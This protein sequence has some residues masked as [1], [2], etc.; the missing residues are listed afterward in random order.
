MAKNSWV[1]LL[2]WFSIQVRMGSTVAW[3]LWSS[4]LDGQEWVRY[5]AVDWA[6]D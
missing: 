6:I 3:I 5:S 2:V 1:R 4:L